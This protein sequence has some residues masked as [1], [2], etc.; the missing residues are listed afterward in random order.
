MRYRPALFI[1]L[2]LALAT[3]GFAQITFG[4]VPS[5][6][7][8]IRSE[9]QA[10]EFT[11]D[12]E[13]RLG[14]AVK[15]RLFNDEA[16]LHSWLNRFREVDLAILS[17]GYIGQQPAG[18]FYALAE[19]LRAG[20]P[21][22]APADPVVARQGLSP[23]L[24]FDLQ[25]A[26]A[27][28]AADP[29]ARTILGMAESKPVPAPKPK[30]VSKPRPQPAPGPA[31][32]PEP[33]TRPEPKAAQRGSESA[34]DSPPR[35]T[36][37][38]PAEPKTDPISSPI[39]KPEPVIE[40]AEP[41]EPASQAAGRAPSTK[42][43]IWLEKENQPKADP[44]PRTA[45]TS[46]PSQESE[47]PAPVQAA[48]A[49]GAF[50]EKA[51]VPKPAA[52]YR[53]GPREAANLN[54]GSSDTPYGIPFPALGAAIASTLAAATLLILRRR[55]KNARDEAFY[56]H[57]TP[58]QTAPE[59]DP[60]EVMSPKGTEE[61]SPVEN[62]REK[63]FAAVDA[64]VQPPA[65]AGQSGPEEV[66]P[67]IAIPTSREALSGSAAGDQ[68]PAGDPAEEAAAEDLPGKS[69]G[70]IVQSRAEDG[71]QTRELS[72]S[73]EGLAAA[74]GA[75]ERD[76]V[77]GQQEPV[78]EERDEDQSAI[79]PAGGGPADDDAAV[80]IPET[81]GEEHYFGEPEA[82]QPEQA[83]E[84]AIPVD[85]EAAAALLA[86][87]ASPAAES[88]EVVEEEGA[89]EVSPPGERKPAALNLQGEVSAIK[90]PALLQLVATQTKPGSL[91][92]T[93]R[94]DEKRLHFRNGKIAMATSINR[95]DRSKTGFLM[96]K[97]G[98]LLIRQGKIT[99]EQR[100]RALEYCEKHP[101]KRIGEALVAQGALSEEVLLEAL[102]NQ[103]E[104]VIFS[105][106]IFPEG[107]FEF[108]F[109]DFPL[110]AGS[111]LRMNIGELMEKTKRHEGE[112]NNIRQGIPSLDTVLDYAEK[113]R[114]KLTSARMT[115]HQ[116]L[117]LSLIDGRRPINEI[118]IAAT[119]L[120]LEVYKFLYFMV[121][122]NI[123]RPVP[124]ESRSATV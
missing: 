123:L 45:T 61:L 100:D 22:A 77:S 89:P 35:A 116:K 99:E 9:S 79:E 8:L 62:R 105:L 108:I 43:R 92:I 65:T 118:C 76:F 98:Y 87:E 3:P 48:P 2:F 82:P 78:R 122:A 38:S 55:G 39:P 124:A 101:S 115:V 60:P 84:E 103:A 25:R 71:D 64:S 28:M 26:L 93:T 27:E 15:L 75:E 112:W 46:P 113:G 21:G 95:A 73:A 66:A 31:P 18:E 41:E 1:V 40:S 121:H 102:R 106:F 6:N 47:A 67:S 34:T 74:D 86:P 96:N 50:Q 7:S 85:E 5:A 68:L 42:P 80:R 54:E 44:L 13:N 20:F 52:S 33:A 16:K 29:T 14:E 117:V 17:R 81:R 24:L 114:D 12:L 107:H 59:N 70:P 104:S 36:L 23:R 119:M 32:M 94:H 49:A 19:N 57:A 120:D 30:Q 11:A 63:A 90:M 58:P 37:A 4:V 10:K 72:E 83:P 88:V 56:W 110:P 97:V 109:E 69:G 51:E 53:G 111:D 91:L